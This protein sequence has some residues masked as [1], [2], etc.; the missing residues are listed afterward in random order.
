MLLLPSPLE[1]ED[2][3]P[4]QDRNRIQRNK[5]SSKNR[6]TISSRCPIKPSGALFAHFV[7]SHFSES[8]SQL[9]AEI[10]INHITFHSYLKIILVTQCKKMYEKSMPKVFIHFFFQYI[11]IVVPIFTIT[12]TIFTTKQGCSHL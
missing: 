7:I 3:A 10:D 2:R 1:R 11:F 8:I 12:V 5:R 4:A 6:Q 9:G